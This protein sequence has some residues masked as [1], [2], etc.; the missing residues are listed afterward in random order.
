MGYAWKRPQK[1][2][3][4]ANA[5]AISA[6][7][8]AIER[9]I[10]AEQRDSGK[11]SFTICRLF[12][13]TSEVEADIAPVVAQLNTYRMQSLDPDAQ[14]SVIALGTP[15]ANP[16]L[17]NPIWNSLGFYS[18][19]NRAWAY[20][21]VGEQDKEVVAQFAKL[22]I[23]PGLEL[24]AEALNEAQRRGLQRA[25]ETAKER[26][27]LHARENGEL[28]NGWRIA[29]NLGAYG[30]NRLLASAVGL[31]GYGGNIAEE[32]MYLPTFLDN[33]SQPLHSD[34]NYRIHFSADNLP[35]VDEFWAVTLYNRP[36]NQLK[37][38][39]TNRYT[40]GDRSPDLQRNADG[41]ID[42]YVQQERPEGDKASNWLPSG[43]SGPIWM[44]MRVYGPQDTA[45]AGGYVPPPVERMD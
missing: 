40:N 30:S 29:T 8:A 2:G 33:Q 12:F 3:K 37:D 39:P 7:L 41:S 19:L 23:G 34:R 10:P 27:M 36:E 28:R 42:I 20:G 4:W 11:K 14:Y 35:P 15:V 9:S 22:G 25:V 6:H 38:N 31:M 5:S 45:L 16:K 13:Y 17:N 21:S 32:A 18:L 26:V 1:I 43:E 24:K 44:M